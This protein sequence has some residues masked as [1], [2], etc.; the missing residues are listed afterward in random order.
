MS[1][2][3]LGAELEDEYIIEAAAQE[4][5]PLLGHRRTEHH[6][7]SVD[8]KERDSNLD[9]LWYR[10]PNLYWLL[11]PFI[12]TATMSGAA[13][14]PRLSLMGDLLCRNYY[15][16]HSPGLLDPNLSLIQ[17]GHQVDCNI[18]EIS[19][20]IARLSTG[21][22][23]LTGVLSALT[24]AK[25]GAWSD[26][27]GR[28]WPLFATMIGALLND[29]CY[30]LVA[31]YYRTLPLG[32]LFV[33]ALCDGL[34]GSFM[35]AMAATYAYTTDV[36]SPARRAV[37]F[38]YFQCCFYA[39]IALGPSLGGYLVT[40]TNNVL[41][42]FYLAMTVHAIFAVYTAL[43]LP[44]S[45]SR[46]RMDQAARRHI[47]DV[48][49]RR[50]ASLA[51]TDPDQSKAQVSFAKM[52]E[53][54]NI[55]K[56]LRVFFPQHSAPAIRRNLK[57]LVGIDLCLLM[58]MGSFTVIILYA[59]L[60]FRWRDLEQGYLLSLIGGS[61]VIVLLG[62]LPIVVR[63]VRGK[64]PK[65][66]PDECAAANAQRENE[67][68]GADMLDI[69]LIRGSLLFESVAFASMALAKTSAGFY[70]GGALSGFA[71]VGTPTLQSAL[72]KHVYETETGQLLGA[73]AL[74][75]SLNRVASPLLFGFLYSLTVKRMPA[76]VFWLIASLMLG[77]FLLS[78][79]LRQ[80]SRDDKQ[81]L[82]ENDD[83]V[84]QSHL[85]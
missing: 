40:K 68:E 84:E 80:T 35:S 39:G 36:V 32:F 60:I 62:I 72:T 69:W 85:Y 11:P 24:A 3:L 7:G 8:G 74:L 2:D 79:G 13:I 75:Q 33:G 34:A 9:L 41:T 82:A 29:L 70:L 83:D 57:L 22:N 17:I 42:I 30:I 56:A 49:A 81:L 50:D 63:L 78:T 1:A 26:R 21:I 15:T 23:I 16:Q 12:F 20:Q 31:K 53:K 52:M 5:A 28:R 65:R 54:A 44:E 14:T 55:F 19:A 71:G 43:L 59:K 25:Y 61:R 58:N 51:L 18:P 27:H 38:G 73:V 76:V 64:Q 48:A 10:K 77:G 47:R 67:P 4:R 37:A 6:D 66:T 46:T 45:L